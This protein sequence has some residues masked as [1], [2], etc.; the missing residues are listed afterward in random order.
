[1]TIATANHKIEPMTTPFREASKLLR[2]HLHYALI[3]SALVNLAYIAPTLYM[4]GV[5]DMVVP[6]GSDLTLVFFTLALGLTLLTLTTLDKLRASIL[7][8]ASLRLDAVFSERLL[9]RAFRPGRG[10]Q[11]RLNQQMREFETVRAAVTG[12]AILA[13]FDVPWIPIYVA[14]C[15]F[16]HPV[17]GV[18]ALASAS[19]LVLLAIWNER[20]T[21]PLSQRALEASAASYALQDSAGVSADVVRALGMSGAMVG[22]L[23]AARQRAN[24][25]ASEAAGASARIGGAI[26]FLRLLLQSS[27][28]AVGAWLAIHKQI[29][30]GAIFASTML[31]SRA[32]A[33]IDSMVAQ[34]RALSGAISAYVAIKSHVCAEE[35]PPATALPRA[36][37]RLK[38]DQIT[39]ASPSR[40]RAILSDVRFNAE[41]G[42]VVGVV[43]ASG[44]GK[45]TLMQVLANARL[46]DRGE[47]RLDGARYG[48][49]DPD[50]LGRWIG[51]V[52]QDSVLFPGTIKEN[53]SRFDAAAGA[54]PEEVDA[55]AVAAAR[56]AGVHDLI[57]AF[58]G[59]YDAVIGPR[60]RGLSA[61]QQ[62][63][64]AIARALYGEPDLFIFDEPNANLDAEGEAELKELLLRLR[65]RGALVIVS[66]HRHS[67][68]AATDLLAVMSHGRLDRFGPTE[69]V[70]GALRPAETR[71]PPR[72]QS[73]APQKASGRTAQAP[74][75]RQLVLASIDPSQGDR[76]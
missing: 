7:Q 10:A 70:L 39:V 3:F 67:L 40:D 28:L 36:R 65:A 34:W 58:E 14:C 38:A 73:A 33:P 71:A 9:R 49:F 22:L 42:Q 69:E 44:A 4:L 43:G 53:I 20:A 45:T 54:D 19:L 52:P 29:S 75:A 74:A 48:D 61:G 17:I 37:P 25:P 46:P 30:G 63:R 15:F 1:M 35:P 76:S 59:G 32:L 47:V 21:R 26:R 50:R 16:L 27:A 41:G 60:G 55:K 12:P 13:L 68:I 72:G 6:A 62:Q 56:E 23:K 51:Y 2:V 5:Y 11:V 31:T 66:V 24:L 57:L 18:L 8:A 64:I